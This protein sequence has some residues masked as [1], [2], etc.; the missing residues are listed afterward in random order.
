MKLKE[1]KNLLKDCNYP[2]NVINQ[3]FDNTKFVLNCQI[4]NQE[5]FHKYLKINILLLRKQ[6]TFQDLIQKL[7]NG[8]CRCAGKHCKICS[9]YIADTASLC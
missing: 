4:S 1:L 8:L 6:N 2:D 7:V 5:I 9:L 3:S